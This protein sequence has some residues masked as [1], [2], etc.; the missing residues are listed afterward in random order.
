M[1]ARELKDHCLT[2]PNTYED[3][4]FGVDADWCI[5]RHCGNRKGFAHIF[6][7]NGRLGINLKCEPMEADFLRNLFADVL[8]AYHMNKTHWNSV[9]P[10]GDVPEEQL[11][12]MIERSFA[13]TKP[14][15]S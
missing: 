13:L 4:P 11:Y 5:I 9:R 14:S 10:N 12:R 1:T 15:T 8:P 7:R 3:Y 2:L 6:E